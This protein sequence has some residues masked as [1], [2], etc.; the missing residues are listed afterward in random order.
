MLLIVILFAC[1]LLLLCL[2]NGRTLNKRKISLIF[3]L[4]LA[5]HAP[6][7]DGTLLMTRFF[8]RAFS[9]AAC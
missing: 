5:F 6:I 4:P 8:L 1:L 2:F 9:L 7:D 3:M